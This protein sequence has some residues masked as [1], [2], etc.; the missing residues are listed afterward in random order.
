LNYNSKI[1]LDFEF[2]LNSMEF[3]NF[4]S[5][6]RFTSMIRAQIT[7]LNIGDVKYV[8]K[9]IIEMTRQAHVGV[10]IGPHYDKMVV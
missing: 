1:I 2:D 8:P 10:S 3:D 5:I 9:Y 7:W 4:D 6:Q